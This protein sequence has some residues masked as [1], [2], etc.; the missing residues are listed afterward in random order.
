MAGNSTLSTP[1]RVIISGCPTITLAR[2]CHFEAEDVGDDGVY[3]YP[4]G[5][6]LSTGVDVTVT[7]VPDSSRL[8]LTAPFRPRRRLARRRAS[9]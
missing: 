7:L 6:R 4:N 3:V 8:R 5:Y 1:Q 2:D 9:R